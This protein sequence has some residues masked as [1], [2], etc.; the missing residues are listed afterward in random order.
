[1]GSMQERRF[2]EEELHRYNGKDGGPAFIAY[3]GRVYDVT[4]SFHWQEGRHQAMHT[5][6]SDVTESIDQAP[7]GT[8]LLERFP[9][10]GI[11]SEK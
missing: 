4:G 8:D 5:A 2:T 1:M 6:G 11:L 7:H 3:G 10:V 9:V